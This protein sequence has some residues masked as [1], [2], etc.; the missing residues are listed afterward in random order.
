MNLSLS[1]CCVNAQQFPLWEE[2]THCLT[3]WF[4]HMCFLDGAIWRKLT[5]AAIWLQHLAQGIIVGLQSPP[6]KPPNALQFHKDQLTQCVSWLQ[7]NWSPW[8][9]MTSPLGCSPNAANFN[10]LTPCSF[11]ATSCLCLPQWTVKRVG[12]TNAS[13]S[14]HVMHPSSIQLAW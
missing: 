4:I 3:Q 14:K 2:I 11:V 8:P 5:C 13:K 12:R 9:N 1:C 7:V 6:P 10:N